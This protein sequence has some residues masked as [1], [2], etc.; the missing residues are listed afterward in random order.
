MQI[1]E[2]AGKACLSELPRTNAPWVMARCGSKGSKINM[3]QMI[4]C[5]G[6]QNVNGARIPNGFDERTLPH[7]PR[8]SKFPA[9]KG[10]FVFYAWIVGT[11][12]F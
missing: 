11:H 5:V 6:Q 8:N 4:A 12:H 9:A 10:M 2:D 7:F 3:S 1:R